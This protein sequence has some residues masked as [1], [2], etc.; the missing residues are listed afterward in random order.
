MLQGNVQF[1]ALMIHDGFNNPKDQLGPDPPMVS[2][3]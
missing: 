2:G 3:E 1:E